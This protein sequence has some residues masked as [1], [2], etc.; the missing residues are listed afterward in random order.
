MGRILNL[1]TVLFLT[2]SCST[3][4]PVK[5]DVWMSDVK[6]GKITHGQD[7]IA[8]TD[9]AFR[10]FKCLRDEE[11]SKLYKACVEASKPWYEF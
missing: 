6:N 2:S 8:C 9:T 1:L 7:S 11:L 5:V 10:Q 3:S 4:D